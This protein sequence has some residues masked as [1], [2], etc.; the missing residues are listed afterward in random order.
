MDWGYAFKTA[1]KMAL[2]FLITG[3][4]G[5]IL[6]AV[7]F[8][9]TAAGAADSVFEESNSG[10]IGFGFFLIVI[11]YIWVYIAGIAV[12]I[13]YLSESVESLIS[14]T[15]RD[16]QNRVAFIQNTMANTTQRQ[17]SQ[18]PPADPAD[19]WSDPSKRD[20]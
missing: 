18:L 10:L 9:L 1:S 3:L 4:V 17:S 11:G 6:I 5:I 2:A 14:P 19:P 20:S 8:G 16:I 7:G 15:L 13:K 12:F